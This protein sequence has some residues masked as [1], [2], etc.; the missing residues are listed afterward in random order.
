ML[1]LSNI[2]RFEIVGAICNPGF[3]EGIVSWDEG[4]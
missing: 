4:E 2:L 1:E 3:G